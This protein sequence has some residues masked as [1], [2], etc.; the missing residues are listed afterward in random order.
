M[1]LI[2]LP[3]ILLIVLTVK[4]ASAQNS[5]FPNSNDGNELNDFLMKKFSVQTFQLGQFV[6]RFN[7]EKVID[8][9]N[10]SNRRQNISLLL[11][12][13]DT[14]LV[15]KAHKIG[16]LDSFSNSRNYLST[17]K[18]IWFAQVSTVFNYKSKPTEIVLHLKLEG[19]S[20]S[21]YSW[22][23]FNV[24]STLFSKPKFD[25][26]SE[27][28]N[29]LNNEITFSE[30][31]K[32]FIN[33]VDVANFYSS[34]TTYSPLSSFR[35]YVKNKDITFSHIQKIQYV[36]MDISG[37]DFT[38]DNYLRIDMNSGWLISSINKK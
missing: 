32:S 15:A 8:V 29:P 37:F 25:K 1:R 21:G 18:S 6:E 11:N 10:K 34:N 4:L 5:N 19:D 2:K 35:D 24:N 7:F 17:E 28:I 14:L 38:V 20:K 13:Q 16:F 26:P 33:N 27:Y 31:S 30:L 22:V 23:I 12:H 36:F 9:G 3:L